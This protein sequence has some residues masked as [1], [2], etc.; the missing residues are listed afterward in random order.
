MARAI[1]ECIAAGDPAARIVVGAVGAGADADADAEEMIKMVRDASPD[2][3]AGI[4]PEYVA[5]LAP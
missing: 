1:E 3:L 4:L 5:G 2:D